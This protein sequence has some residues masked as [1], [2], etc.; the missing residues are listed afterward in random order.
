MPRL[1]VRHLAV[2]AWVAVCA[3][4]ALYI[5]ERIGW[6]TRLRPAPPAAA[7]LK[8]DPVAPDLLAEYSLP[9]LEKNYLQILERPLFVPTRRPAP[10]P[11]PP[12]PPPKPTMQKGQFQLMGVMILP[13]TSFAWLKEVAGGKTRKVEKGKTLNGILLSDVQPERVTLSQYDDTEVV[14]MKV[15]PSGQPSGPASAQPGQ[16]PA[17]APVPSL[18]ARRLRLAPAEPAAPVPADPAE[19]K[20]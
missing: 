18:P 2:I 3:G 8:P 6:G 5:G 12:P 7:V 19:T 13:E 10:P 11:P 9:D 14:A 16:S 17:S 20:R 15:Q 1:D 4:L